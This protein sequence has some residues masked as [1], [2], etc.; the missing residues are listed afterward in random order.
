MRTA[1]WPARRYALTA[2]ELSETADSLDA[3]SCLDMSVSVNTAPIESL[4]SPESRSRVRIVET[5]CLGAP[6]EFG[7]GKAIS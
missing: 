4:N 7:L 1:K 2:H 3:S 6:S 5:T